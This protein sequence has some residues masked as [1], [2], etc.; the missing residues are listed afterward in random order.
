M[1]TP[2]GRFRWSRL[3]FDLNESNETFQRKLNDALNRLKGVFT[4]ADDI[5]IVGCDET[6][7][8]AK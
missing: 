7:E 1:I 8:V 5:V 3:P 6:G 4:I 2:F